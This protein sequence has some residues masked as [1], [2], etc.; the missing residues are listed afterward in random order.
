MR[1]APTGLNQL[2]LLPTRTARDLADNPPNDPGPFRGVVP[3]Y[4]NRRGDEPRARRPPIG[5]IYHPE[6]WPE[7][8]Q[9]ASVEPL[10]PEGRRLLRRHTD[11]LGF[12]PLQRSGTWPPRDEDAEDLTLFETRYEAVVPGSEG[13]ISAGTDA[14]RE[15][16]LLSP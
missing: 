13:G 3:A 5:L 12:R 4:P 15:L 14:K 2:N 9:R 11:D 6:G 16:E 7:R 10:S 1:R 8:F